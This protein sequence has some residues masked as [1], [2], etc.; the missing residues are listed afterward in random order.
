MRRIITLIGL[1]CTAA[2]AD[3]KL[4][5]ELGPKDLT[6]EKSGEGVSWTGAV[7]SPGRYQVWVSYYCGTKNT[8]ATLR[9]NNADKTK[10]LLYMGMETFK[11][12]YLK[13]GSIVE[14]ADLESNRDKLDPYHFREYWGTFELKNDVS[15]QMTFASRKKGTSDVHIKS[16]ELQ[17]ER[18]FNPKLEPLLFSGIDFY[19]YQTTP[20]G[21]V[22]NAYDVGKEPAD[23]AS[24][25]TCGVGLMAYS[26]NHVLDRDPDAE[27]KA[28]NTLRLYNNKHPT[29]QPARHHTGFRYHFIS[30]TDASG[31]S[32]FSTIDTSILIC[33]ALMAR[34]TFDSREIRKEADEL[35]NSVDWAAAIHDIPQQ[36]FHMLG[37]SI[38]GKED[39][40]TT[41][42]NEYLLLAWLIQQYENQKIDKPLQVMP[43]MDDLTKSVYKGRVILT[44]PF[45]EI[46]P[47]FLV[48]FP[49]YMTNLCTDE[50]FFSYVAA[51]AWADR[52]H[53]MN[54][55]GIKGAWGVSAG[56][57]PSRDRYSVNAFYDRNPDGV[58]TPR[59]IA[60]FIPTD[61]IA[62]DDL[63]LL[64]K[65][66]KLHMQTPFGVILSQWSPLHPDWKPIR[67]PG[68]DYSSWLFGMAAYHP[69]LGMNFFR[70]KTKFT[71]NLKD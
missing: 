47:S 46:Q 71:F 12:F 17:K 26:I 66:K 45:G 69:K 25:A 8:E 22:R 40:I 28:L 70:E 53:G 52:E 5:I 64:F 63:G 50:R 68:I 20:D 6:R 27:Q 34:N 19:N 3:N 56:T 61:P 31:S 7:D 29:L 14:A 35:W 21:F 36:Q 54:R 43:N 11:R 23:S 32:K 58:V 9:L 13:D 30:T 4:D 37:K 33:G 41:L 38:D 49:F 44:G 57:S 42:Y 18:A 2:L 65:N 16:I 55:F 24:V 48:Q 51:Q 62:A 39:S 15:L 1:L 10:S 60:G 59:M 67:I